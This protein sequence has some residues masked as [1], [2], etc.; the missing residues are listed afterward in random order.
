MDKV[1]FH[2]EAEEEYQAALAW[3]QARSPRSAER[4]EVET[5]HVLGMIAANSSMFARYGEEHQLV[6][7][8]R[9]PFSVVYRM[10]PNHVEVVALAHSRRSAGYWRGRT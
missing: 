2:P 5:E 1:R 9:F 10:H 8:R 4:F 7:L 3:Y 6:M